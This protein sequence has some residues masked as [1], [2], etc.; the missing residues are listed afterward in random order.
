MNL[1]HMSGTPLVRPSTYKSKVG[2]VSPRCE[3]VQICE[4]FHPKRTIP[5]KRKVRHS[6]KRCLLWE[7]RIFPNQVLSALEMG[8]GPMPPSRICSILHR[9][10][11]PPTLAL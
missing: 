6:T 5:S 3:I 8:I 4:G 10:E 9:E 2:G 7:E 1:S 11:T